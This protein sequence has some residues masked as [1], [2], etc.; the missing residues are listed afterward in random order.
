MD[1]QVAENGMY[2]TANS[3]YFVLGTIGGMQ[4][5]KNGIK[6]IPENVTV[7]IENNSLVWN[8]NRTTKIK[9]YS[10][11]I[12]R[13]NL[14]AGLSVLGKRLCDK[15][16]DKEKYISQVE[17]IIRNR[18]QMFS[19]IKGLQIP[20]CP[21]YKVYLKEDYEYAAI[22]MYVSHLMNFDLTKD[23]E[24]SKIINDMCINYYGFAEVIEKIALEENMTL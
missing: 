18:S 14:I 21:Q 22:F 8:E 13:Q 16:A 3:V 4:V 7:V 9:K 5:F 6:Q 23:K 1:R 15:I 11:I 2:I 12:D 24:F 19:K 10:S 20:E 17:K